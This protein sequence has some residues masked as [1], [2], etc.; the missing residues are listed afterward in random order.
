MSQIL[1]VSR[2]FTF[3]PLSAIYHGGCSFISPQLASIFT[4]KSKSLPHNFFL[5]FFTSTLNHVLLIKSHDNIKHQVFGWV[6]SIQGTIVF[7]SL[8]M[9]ILIQALVKNSTLLLNFM[10][11]HLIIFYSITTITLICR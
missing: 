4:S 6:P 9:L 8:E 3:T 7:I 1:E 11:I 2:G 10:D 5:V